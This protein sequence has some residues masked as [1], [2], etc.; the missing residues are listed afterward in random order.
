MTEVRGYIMSLTV[1]TSKGEKCKS[2]KTEMKY[3]YTYK[4]NFYWKKVG[5]DITQLYMSF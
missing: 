1:M 4:N 2:N 5:H 3:R